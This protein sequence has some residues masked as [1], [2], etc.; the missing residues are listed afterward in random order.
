M[1]ADA[2]I[3]A[4]GTPA[5]DGG[6]EGGEA[7]FAVPEQYSDRGWASNVKSLDDVYSQFD[8]AQTMLGKKTIPGNDATHEQL[9]E[10]YSQLRP[11]TLDGYELSLP[12][13]MEVD[14]NDEQQ[15]AYKQ[16]FSDIGLTPRQANALY[17]GSAKLEVEK[18]AKFLE[19]Q[20]TEEQLNTEF[21]KVLEEKYG[22]KAD[23]AIKITLQHALNHSEET[24]AALADL[25]NAQML[26][27][28]DLV[29]SMHGKIPSEEGAP[30]TGDPASGSKSLEQKVTEANE[31]RR[32]PE[33]KDP[34]HK[35]NKSKREQLKALD[36][37]IQKAYK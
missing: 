26:A 35:D 16:L 11:E 37:A 7:A 19:G 32:S 27:M 15:A 1:T 18:A 33:I 31:L 25:P 4:G 8:N 17:Q 21:D 3:D 20:P 28:V 30:G 34:F 5:G 9:E 36:D 2:A 6:A 10:F 23:E 13:G 29:Y 22:D 14:V 24:K 12:E